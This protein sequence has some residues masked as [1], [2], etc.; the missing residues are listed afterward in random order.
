MAANIYSFVKGDQ[1]GY[2]L[3]DIPGL[4]PNFQGSAG[5]QAISNITYSDPNGTCYQPTNGGNWNNA[6]RNYWYGKFELWVN[7]H[8]KAPHRG[9]CAYLDFNVLQCYKTH[10]DGKVTGENLKL[11]QKRHCWE[12]AGGR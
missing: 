4:T 6:T 5:A 12:D 3:P 9:L 10:G 1:Y 7:V 8:V 2:R 11:W